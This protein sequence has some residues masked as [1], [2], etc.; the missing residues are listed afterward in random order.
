MHLSRKGPEHAWHKLNSLKDAQIMELCKMRGI[1]ELK[2]GRESNMDSLKSHWRYG[3]VS[4]LKVYLTEASTE[5]EWAYAY[6]DQKAGKMVH[7]AAAKVSTEIKVWHEK[8]HGS[9]SQAL[10]LEGG[11][12]LTC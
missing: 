8:V 7:A 5:R 10:V 12:K 1:K 3:Q 11:C 9:A 2:G 4:K 6:F